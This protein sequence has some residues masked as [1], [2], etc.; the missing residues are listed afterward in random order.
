MSRT[1]RIELVWVALSVAVAGAIAGF[2]APFPP[3]A[4]YIDSS[5]WTRGVEFVLVIIVLW[6]LLSAVGIIRAKIGIGIDG[7]TVERLSGA[8]IESR[9]AIE[10]MQEE[11]GQLQARTDRLVKTWEAATPEWLADHDKRIGALEESIRT[12]SSTFNADSPEG[13][14]V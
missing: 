11:L 6:A 3:L 14:N 4:R 1:R 2:A 13:P 7:L 9:N 5:A 8:T 10:G 12:L